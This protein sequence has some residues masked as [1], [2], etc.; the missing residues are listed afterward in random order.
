MNELERKQRPRSWAANVT[1]VPTCAHLWTLLALLGACRL[2]GATPEPASD[3]LPTGQVVDSIA[4]LHD[5]GQ[6]YA[7]YLPSTYHAD[8]LWPILYAF[9]AGARGRVPVELFREPAERFGYV[10]VGSNNSR[11]GPQAPIVAAVEAIWR[12]THARL[13]LDPK[14]IYATGMSGGTFPA[15]L[16]ATAHGAGII[17][18]GGATQPDPST[19]EAPQFAWLGIAGDADFNLVPTRDVVRAFASRGCTARF[20]TFDGGHSWPPKDVAAR[21]IE[22]LEV[23]GMRDGLRPRDAALVDSYLAT[24]VARAQEALAQGQVGNASTE[25]AALGWELRG[26]TDVSAIEREASRLH[27][28]REAERERKRDARQTAD[29]VARSQRLFALLA[30]LERPERLALPMAVQAPTPADVAD[31]SEARTSFDVKATDDGLRRE[32]LAE[33]G[34]LKHDY[35]SKERDRRLRARRIIEGFHVGMQQRGRD[36]LTKGD[37][38]PA[39]IAFELCLEILPDNAGT[40]YEL[41]RAQAACGRRKAALAGLR[42]AVAKGFAGLTRLDED[43]EWTALRSGEE[44]RAIVTQLRERQP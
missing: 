30:Q 23:V 19:N 39:R 38:E 33:I 32:L 28:T 24:G 44:Y 41:A 37:P 5:A 21:A 7:F 16:V 20:L 11:N 31:P 4:C 9:H 17:A 2:W 29:E 6:R 25:Y 26:L 18:C 36:N 14:R 34:S 13:A 27:D 8:R 42:R 22:W 10:V 12:D 35:D 3:A 43:P 1:H 40:L 15:A